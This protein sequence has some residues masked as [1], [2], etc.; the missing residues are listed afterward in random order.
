MS[1]Y[2]QDIAAYT[3]QSECYESSS[4]LIEKLLGIQISDSTIHRVCQRWGDVSEKLLTE[5]RTEEVDTERLKVDEVVYAH[6]DGGMLLTR[7]DAWKE[8]KVGRVYRSAELMKAQENRGFIK[9][10]W[11]VFHIGGHEE[12][13]NKMSEYL[14]QYEKLQ[15]RLIFIVDGAKWIN[16]WITA[17]YPKAQQILDYYHAIE[18]FSTFSK[19][20]LSKDGQR[21]KWLEAIKEHLL[22]RGVA[23]ITTK[24][25][26]IK[27]KTKRQ[28]EAKRKLLVYIENNKHRM[29]YP[30]YK[31]NG[32]QIGSGAMEAAHRTLVQRR[33]K[34][35]GQR[36]TIPGATRII[37]LRNLRMNGQ[38]HRLTNVLRKT[39]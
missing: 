27:C 29:D 20:S 9:D 30:K 14:D 36:W 7:T 8:V 25:D 33:C 11:Y 26:E 3:G 12:F 5:E 4:E 2:L 6:C 22:K 28:Q 16:N 17:E 21:Q 19:L 15:E 18:H 1:P 32:L 38:W 35:S 23:E 31:S 39:A 13:E 34:L 37:N 10:S 24:I